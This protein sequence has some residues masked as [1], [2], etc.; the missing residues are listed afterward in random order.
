MNHSRNVFQSAISIALVMLFSTYGLAAAVTGTGF[1]IIESHQI[2][3]D[4]LV[5]EDADSIEVRL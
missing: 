4:S 5:V 3:T 1:S 2:V